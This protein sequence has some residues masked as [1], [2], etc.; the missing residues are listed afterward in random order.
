MKNVTDFKIPETGKKLYLSVIL[1]LYD[2][3]PVAYVVSYRNDNKL[4]FDT[5]ARAIAANPEA[6]HCSIWNKQNIS[7]KAPKTGG[8]NNPCRE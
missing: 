7:E 5:Y 8:W 3:I 2:R 4:V 1:D 6:R